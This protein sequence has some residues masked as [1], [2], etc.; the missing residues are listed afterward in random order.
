MF[1]SKSRLANDM[2]LY[3]F[4]HYPV[5]VGLETM[6]QR[7]LLPNSLWFSILVGFLPLTQNIFRQPIPEN[8][9]PP[10]PSSRV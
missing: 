1:L 6:A 9:T 4:H 2:P 7:D 8:C 5:H 10:P 3:L